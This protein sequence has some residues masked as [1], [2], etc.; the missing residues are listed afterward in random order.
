MFRNTMSLEKAPVDLFMKFSVGAV[1]APTLNASQS[2]GIKSMSR[3]GVG[4]YTINF[5]IASGPTQNDNYKRCMMV[6][7]I[8]LAASSSTASV[9]LIA[10]NSNSSTAPNI[11]IQFVS[12]PGVAVEVGSGEV[13]LLE[14]VLSNTSV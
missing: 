1:G 3:T 6:N 2:V 12:A 8:S 4:A 11:Q 9:Q 10:D 7:Y 13:I 14:I 5:G